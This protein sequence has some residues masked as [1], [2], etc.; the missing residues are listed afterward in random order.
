MST[1]K[2]ARLLTCREADRFY[3]R[4]NGTASQAWKRGLLP[5]RREGKR[6]LVSA[7]RAEELWGVR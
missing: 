4:A 2:D 6:I 3:R 7:K 5:G 1:P